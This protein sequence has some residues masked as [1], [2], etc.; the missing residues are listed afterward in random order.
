MITVPPLIIWERDDW[1]GAFEIGIAALNSSDDSWLV[2]AEH[3]RPLPP[4]E[5]LEAYTV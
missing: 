3:V 1:M 4:S 2:F 5:H